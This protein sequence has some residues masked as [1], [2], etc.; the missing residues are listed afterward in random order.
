M[1]PAR[2]L[3]MVVASADPDVARQRLSRPPAGIDLSEL[4]I[5]ALRSDART[6]EQVAALVS[7]SSLPV[8]AT[9]RPRDES[10]FF[11]GDDAA[12]WVLLDAALG[13]GATLA[14]VEWSRIRADPSL[15]KHW[16]PRTPWTTNSERRNARLFASC[17]PNP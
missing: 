4:R 10:G 8:V 3:V 15:V 1:K 13:A 17:F 16:P 12:R 6:P 5:D 2:N 7:A 14:D 11:D 9:C